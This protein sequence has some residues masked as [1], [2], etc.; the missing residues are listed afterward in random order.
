MDRGSKSGAD[1]AGFVAIRRRDGPWRQVYALV[2]VWSKAE[3]G[4]A[5]NDQKATHAGRR[6]RATAR[7]IRLEGAL[8]VGTSPR[9]PSSPKPRTLKSPT[10][11]TGFLHDLG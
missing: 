10:M 2:P 5:G 11:L 4:F 6:P 9:M 8:T 7:T 3:C 1:S